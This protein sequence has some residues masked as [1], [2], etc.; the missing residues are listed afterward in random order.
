MNEPGLASIGRVSRPAST[1]RWA[2]AVVVAAGWTVAC[3]LT[4]EPAGPVVREHHVVE[5]GGAT[6]AR[7]EIDMSAGEL[8]VKSGATTL[9]EGDFDFNIPA[10][11][12]AIAYAVSGGTGAL[13]VSQGSAS[14]TYENTWR[15][16]LDETMPVDL[17]VSLAAGDAELVVGGL[18]LNSLCHSSRCRRRRRRSARYA[19]AKLQCAGP[20]RRRRYHDSS[21]ED[22]RH[23]RAHVRSDWRRYCPWSRAARRTLDQPARGKLAGHRR[24]SGAARG[25]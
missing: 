24:P 7:I 12:P 19:G 17:E 25:W 15:L 2:I 6:R 8:E 16:S 20:G 13:K 23:L 21:A 9:L 22:G 18:N 4:S 5:R 14:G 3:G 11:K 10:L 1:W